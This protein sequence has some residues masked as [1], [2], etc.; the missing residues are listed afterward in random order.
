[1]TTFEIPPAVDTSWRDDLQAAS[2]A[3]TILRLPAAG[4]DAEHMVDL[5]RAAGDKIC[6]KLDRYD[7]IPGVLPGTPPEPLRVAHANVTVNLWR[8][9]D[10]PAGV[11]GSWAP[12]DV[13]EMIPGDPLA[14]QMHLI[15]PYKGRWGIG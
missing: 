6:Q 1:M 13:T 8:S 2:D 15:M 3:L 9:K 12:D 4:I 10:A 14:G 11:I 5:A 7:P